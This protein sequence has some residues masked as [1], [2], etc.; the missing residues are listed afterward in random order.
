MN[1]KWTRRNLVT[2]DWI[3]I[4]VQAP[5]VDHGIDATGRHYWR[6]T[7][8]EPLCL[9]IIEFLE[10]QNETWMMNPMNYLQAV[11]FAVEHEKTALLIRMLFDGEM[12]I[13]PV[14]LRPEQERYR[15]QLMK[16]MVPVAGIEPA[17]SSLQN[18]RSTN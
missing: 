18:S 16:E 8:V 1:L 9:Q 5:K 7:S 6:R 2:R 14:I 10:E 13:G 17:T 12:T 4:T 11:Q 3:K 15:R